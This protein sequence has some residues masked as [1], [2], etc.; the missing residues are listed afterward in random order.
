MLLLMSIM[1]SYFFGLTCDELGPGE[2]R[3]AFV[4]DVIPSFISAAF[5]DKKSPK[6]TL[7]Q[8]YFVVPKHFFLSVFAFM[9]KTLELL[10]FALILLTGLQTKTCYRKMFG[11][12]QGYYSYFERWYTIVPIHFVCL[13]ID[14]LILCSYMPLI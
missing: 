6:Y 5:E 1:D 12:W 8:L 10:M 9:W 11:L 14:L 2:D 13:F 7:S 4:L 3:G